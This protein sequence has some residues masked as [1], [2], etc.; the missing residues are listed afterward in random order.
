M[1]KRYLI[2]NADDYGLLHSMN[3]AINELFAL[4]AITS[5]TVLAPAACAANAC[6]LARQNK[7]AVGVHWALHSEWEDA[8]WRPCAGSGA[9]P[10]LTNAEGML[11][12]NAA[13]MGKQAKSKDVTAELEAQYHYLVQNGCTPT[14]ADSHGGT[15]YGTNG[16]LFFINAFRVC[17]R[18][19]LPFRFAKTTGFMARQ[20][21][22]S[23][24]SHLKAA[25]K[26]IVGLAAF[27]GVL[28]LDNFVTNPFPAA[29]T[30]GYQ[31]L[32]CYYEAQLAT[33]PAGITEVFMHPALPNDEMQTKS[34][35]W[36]KRIWEYQYLKSG[37]LAQFAQKEGFELVGWNIFS[38]L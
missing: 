5:S 24:P 2:V 6:A 32:C 4:G 10:S 29:K 3:T 30:G 26:A 8:P 19:N 23:V 28:L 34:P 18:H 27:M 7:Q 13:Q 1:N 22:G 16:R 14:H 9:V 33:A 12:A 35:E 15:L 17:H 38:R 36:Q 21:G 11:L 25:H 37:H 31:G 20:F